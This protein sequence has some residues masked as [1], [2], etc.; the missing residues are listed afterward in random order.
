MILLYDL[1]NM[2]E[3]LFMDMGKWDRKTERQKEKLGW[4]NELYSMYNSNK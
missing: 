4:K 1:W 3:R 2:I